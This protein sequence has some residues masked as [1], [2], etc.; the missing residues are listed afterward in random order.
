MRLFIHVATLL[1]S[2]L[3]LCTE[4]VHDVFSLQGME[5]DMEMATVP[6]CSLTMQVRGIISILI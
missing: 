4:R 2:P 5:M 3:V 6:V 1:S